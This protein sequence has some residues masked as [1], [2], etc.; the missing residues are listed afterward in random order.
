MT[1]FIHSNSTRNKMCKYIR[2]YVK[3]FA[4]NFRAD[5]RA[6]A[7]KFLSLIRKKERNKSKEVFN[8]FISNF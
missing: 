6:F 1:T 8:F 5:I 7:R 4:A 3:D 2:S